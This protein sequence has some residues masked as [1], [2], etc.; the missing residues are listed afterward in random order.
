MADDLGY[1]DISCYGSTSINT[2]N[3][4][5]LASTGMKFTDF[6]SNG[7]VCSPTRAALLTGKY[8]Q[9]T[10]IDG[11]ITAKNHRDVGLSLEEITL[12]E[13]L[14]KYDYTCGM[15]GKWHLG[16]AKEFN[17]VLQG[18]DKFI[19]YVSGNIDYHSHVDMG[20]YLDWWKG[21]TVDNEEGYSTDLI[22][23]NGIKFIQENDP[24]KT[25]KPFFLY[26]PHEAPHG[27]YQRR[28]DQI[29]RKVGESESKD[30][31]K[32]SITSIYKEMVEVMD[33]G[34]GKI[35]Q[36]L[37]ETNQYENTILIFISDNGGNHYGNNGALRGYKA[38]AYEGG[39][40]VPAI[41]TYPNK[42]KNES[43]NTEVVLTMDLLP[44]L[45]D[46]IGEKPTNKTIDGI[47]IKES[48]LNNQKLAERDVFFAYGNKSF[49]RRGDWKLIRTRRKIGNRIELYNFANDLGEQNDLSTK[50]TDLADTLLVALEAWDQDVTKDVK[51]LAR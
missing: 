5:L 15:F 29:L 41:F 17:P 1:G 8:Q 21:N 40:R 35:V 24:K 20:G 46:F 25:G 50:R 12:A 38:S 31:C 14:Q 42:I 10:G 43:L 19:G 18:F 39:S 7:A 44:T 33:E 36:T 2:P 26:L 4:D 49:I 45:L 51:V 13:E 16:Y 9:R 27:P 22:T 30:V 32:D 3:I 28:I 37:K 6:H 34:I 11:V 48:L 47:S 23:K